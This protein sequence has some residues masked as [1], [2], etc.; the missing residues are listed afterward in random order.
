[1]AVGSRGSL[2]PL[3]DGDPRGIRSFGTS[4]IIVAS[5][6]M[7]A[8][9]VLLYVIL[10]LDAPV[11]PPP[12]SSPLPILLPA[13][14][15]GVIALSSLTMELGVRSV[16]RARRWALPGW[17]AITFCLGLVFLVLV[18]WLW[19]GLMSE[20]F[21]S[22]NAH[23]GLFYVMTAF[24]GLHVLV[25]LGLVAWLYL[26][27]KRGRHHGRDTVAVRMVGRFWHFLG[28]GWLSK[29]GRAHV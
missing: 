26:G 3:P 17:L 23:G 7:F 16:R 19:G 12:D 11:W 6:M 15:T 2:T 18:G 9:L 5:A 29:I 20:G 1:M 25:A 14:A 8:G 28:L 24:H 27:A 10:R 21:R 22:T 13:L 4:L